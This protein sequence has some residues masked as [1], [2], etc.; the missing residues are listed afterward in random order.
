MPWALPRNK[1]C[2]P[3]ALEAKPRS[4]SFLRHRRQQ[5]LIRAPGRLLD[6]MAQPLARLFTSRSAYLRS[7][8]SKLDEYRSKLKQLDD[9]TP[10]LL[11]NSGLPG[12]R[13]NL[14]LALAV[15]ELASTTQ[16]ETMLAIPAE[17]APENS[18]QVFLVFCGLTALG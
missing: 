12:P 1:R 8:M 15:A 5:G 4:A 14:E 6:R 3:P 18:P 10:F 9:W 2:I 7:L 11:R 16:V 13:G 17:Q